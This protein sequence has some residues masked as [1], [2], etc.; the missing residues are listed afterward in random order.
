MKSFKLHNHAEDLL[1]SS[2]LKFAIVAGAAYLVW[3]ILIPLSP[4][5]SQITIG[6]GDSPAYCRTASNLAYGNGLVEDYFIGDYLGGKYNY[7]TSMG[8]LPVL[9]TGYLYMVFGING[10]SFP[11]SQIWYGIIV[12]ILLADLIGRDAFSHRQ[13]WLWG[14]GL[15]FLIWPFSSFHI[16]MGSSVT[17]LALGS[18]FLIYC[19]LRDDLPRI[20]KVCGMILASSTMF[21]SRPEGFV[22]G[23]LLLGLMSIAFFWKRKI[24][25]IHFITLILVLGIIFGVT[26]VLD[27]LPLKFKNGSLFTLKFNP[28]S[29]VF[30]HSSSDW[31]VFNH[32]LCRYY[33]AGGSFASSVNQHMGQLISI[34]PLQFAQFVFQNTQSYFN[35]ISRFIA[36]SARNTS[37]FVFWLVIFL[38][39][40][41]RR[42]LIVILGGVLFVV[43]LPLLNVGSTDR[44]FFAMLI[45]LIALAWRSIAIK[46]RLPEIQVRRS[47]GFMAV[48]VSI[49][50]FVFNVCAVAFVRIDPKN[51]GYRDPLA[52]INKY[53]SAETV[54]ATSYPQLLACMTGKYAFGG[55]WLAEYLKATITRYQPDYILLDNLRD[56]P[57]NYGY[58][59]KRYKALSYGNELS[60]YDIIQTLSKS[61]YTILSRKR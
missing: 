26:N 7:L 51:T 46:V 47:I 48:G 20:L 42:H 28:I 15:F 13:G 43:L 4:Y 61:R 57:D 49:F 38:G 31:S 14:A 18:V 35:D 5:P 22:L 24:P 12:I 34:Y 33:L 17:M 60:K 32:S 54:I 36:S 11:V 55:T 52:D 6:Y 3:I 39:I 27:N 9:V 58:F 41:G 8:A 23:S 44:H 50:C 40:L 25:Y 45:L 1:S 10:F 19:F 30:R 2:L 59:M 53:S 56:G 21:I 16:G 37:A 29:D